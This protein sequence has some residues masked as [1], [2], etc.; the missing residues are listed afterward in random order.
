MKIVHVT[1]HLGGGVGRVLS[2]I[3]KYRADSGSPIQEQ[4]ICL[5]APE[6]NQYVDVLSDSGIEVIFPESQERFNAL[7]TAAD[8]VQIEWWHHPLLY[9]WMAEKQCVD[10][11]LVMWA[12]TSGLHYPAIPS[13]LVRLP[14]AFLFT[15]PLSLEAS[16]THISRWVT[17]QNTMVQVVHSS[18]G[19]DNFPEISRTIQDRPLRCG[20]LGSLNYAKLHPDI[21]D[22]IRAV[23]IPLFKLEFFGD[24][25][26]N[27]EFQRMAETPEFSD[28]V[29]IRGFT[30][31]P[32][33]A[34]QEMD[35][36]IY[37]LNPLHYGTTENALLEAMACG[38]VPV[39][40]NNPVES[41]IVRHNETGLVVDKPQTFQ[42]EITFLNNNPEERL[43]LSRAAAKEIRSR[44][45]LEKTERG[46]TECY[47]EVMKTPKKA[48][49]LRTVIGHT[50]PEW[51]RSC[52]GKYTNCFPAEHER[53]SQPESTSYP[54][55]L[56][57]PAKSSIFHY[58]KYFS[59]DRQLQRWASMLRGHYA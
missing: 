4:F 34:F 11:R 53:T 45:S 27:P 59:D 31:R 20:Y 43:R 44:F 23:D 36:F 9:Q 5:E 54:T 57:E 6:K 14:H 25:E 42:E 41:S 18:G 19:F 51:F 49:D 40:M 50:P 16:G 55:F 32:D 24:S 7:L 52:L 35:L 10:M 58:L 22:Y 28:R 8:I 47:R 37:L 29:H 46:L 1:A 15:T 12:H 17:D 2:S 48:F 38:V 26:A 21:F 56:Y 33:L 39:V 13:A 30:Q 3:A